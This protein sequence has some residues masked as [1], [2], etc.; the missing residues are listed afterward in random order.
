MRMTIGFAAAL[1]VTFAT[2]TVS[3]P[4]AEARVNVCERACRVVFQR[5]GSNC[6]RKVKAGIRLRQ[7]QC[8]TDFQSTGFSSRQKCRTAARAYGNAI[9]KT[10]CGSRAD[11][12]LNCCRAGGTKESCGAVKSPSGAFVALDGPLL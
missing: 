3:V 12:C 5:G 11:S 2:L 8:K 1:M 7:K 10:S 9:M 4:A 6:A